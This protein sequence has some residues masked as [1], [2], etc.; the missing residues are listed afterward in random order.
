[1]SEEGQRGQ[2]EIVGA[3]GNNIQVLCEK[4]DLNLQKH[5]SNN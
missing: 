4:N 5:S 1:M 3:T 2:R